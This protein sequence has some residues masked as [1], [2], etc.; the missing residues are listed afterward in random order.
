MGKAHPTHTA[1]SG[2]RRDARFPLEERERRT[3]KTALALRPNSPAGIIVDR[4]RFLQPSL[5]VHVGVRT[6]R[7]VLLLQRVHVETI[8]PFEK[9]LVERGISPPLRLHSL[10]GQRVGVAL[11]AL[12]HNVCYLLQQ[13]N[14]VLGGLPLALLASRRLALVAG[15]RRV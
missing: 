4:A 7:L 2:G 14:L 5:I 6:E 3:A 15:G 8:R 9:F 1:E 13:A 11:E 12:L 10:L